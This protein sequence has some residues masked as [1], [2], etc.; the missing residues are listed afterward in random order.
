MINAEDTGSFLTKTFA[1]CLVNIKSKFDNY[2]VSKPSL[3]IETY[4]I[5][6]IRF[7][8]RESQCAMMLMNL[9]KTNLNISE[10]ADSSDRR[11]Q[12]VK[13]NESW[14]HTICSQV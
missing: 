7:N 6:L 9:K 5:S 10:N 13:E 3:C 2:V 4:N 8:C 12:I 14:N 1:F 11:I